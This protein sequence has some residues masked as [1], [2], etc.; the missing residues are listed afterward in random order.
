MALHEA[1]VDHY[2]VDMTRI[3]L[4]DDGS[5]AVV[6]RAHRQPVDEQHGSRRP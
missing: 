1:T 2:G 5:A 3:G 6:Q 4:Q